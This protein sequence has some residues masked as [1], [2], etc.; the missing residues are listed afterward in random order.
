M[1]APELRD[2]LEDRN[3]KVV[4]E[5][6]DVSYQKLTRWVRGKESALSLEELRKLMEY[7]KK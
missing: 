2:R 7:L 3:L 6:I 1:T 4:A 5:R